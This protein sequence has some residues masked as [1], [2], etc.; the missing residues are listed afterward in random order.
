MANVEGTTKSKYNNF[1]ETECK[2]LNL[3]F[4]YLQTGLTY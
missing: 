4:K 1:G 2:V 3:S